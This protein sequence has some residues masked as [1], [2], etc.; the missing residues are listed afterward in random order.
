MWPVSGRRWSDFEPVLMPLGPPLW[1]VTS[2]FLA[3]FKW[4][5]LPRFF[6]LDDVSQAWR[7]EVIR[8][9]QGLLLDSPLQEP[10]PGGHGFVWQ[11]I[12]C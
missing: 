4:L 2:V 1:Q 9:Y 12:N 10:M 11:Q 7:G 3:G 8:K 6:L 5:P